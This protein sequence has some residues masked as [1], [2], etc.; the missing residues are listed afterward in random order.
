MNTQL[1]QQQQQQLQLELNQLKRIDSLLLEP[2]HQTSIFYFKTWNYTLQF[3][4]FLDLA[5]FL[6]AKKL[7]VERKRITE[8]IISNSTTKNRFMGRI[9]SLFSKLRHK[10]SGVVITQ[11]E[12]LPPPLYWIESN[13]YRF[14][15]LFCIFWV[16]E[17][18]RLAIKHA[19]TYYHAEKK[20]RMQSK[21]GAISIR[22]KFTFCLIFASIV[23]LYILL[24]PIKWIQKFT[25]VFSTMGNNADA[26]M[27]VCESR[28]CNTFSIPY[29]IIL[30]FMVPIVK[31]WKAFKGRSI[32][33]HIS[34]FLTK[35]PKIEMT[36]Y[37]IRN[38]I[39]FRRR[40]MQVIT[41]IKS[42]KRGLPIIKAI[43][44]IRKKFIKVVKLKRQQYEA[45][46]QRRIQKILWGKMTDEERRLKAVLRIQSNFRKHR[47]EKEVGKRVQLQ[48]NTSKEETIKL[49]QQTLMKRAES[50]RARDLRISQWSNLKERGDELD[51]EKKQI[52]RSIE[53]EL[54]DSLKFERRVMAI[55]K[56][57]STFWGTWHSM[58]FVCIVLE[59]LPPLLQ[60]LHLDEVHQMIRTSVLPEDN[61]FMVMMWNV[62]YLLDALVD[63]FT[64][65]FN[66]NGELVPEG[67]MARCLPLVSKTISNPITTTFAKSS[68]DLCFVH[69][70]P[71]R[72]SRWLL[73]FIIPFGN[74][75]L[76]IMIWF[77]YEF[78][79]KCN[80]GLI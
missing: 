19:R 8:T 69:A 30:Y 6:Y 64:G 74:R 71:S 36:S 32:I 11:E 56:P 23:F 60:L 7:G 43:S 45:M 67:F 63:F 59:N 66:E 25:S 51:G 12:H 57:T 33:R 20:G 49:K 44:K 75:L 50:S 10:D 5:S 77:W 13:Q 22:K 15:I 40:I 29:A 54:F 58:V 47:S 53:K 39:A 80:G 18:F 34:S 27:D 70:G 35:I 3:V 78:V 4:A 55:I 62:I 26:D 14:D 24:L 76:S 41:A 46:K 38:P 9:G 37:I 61:S 16:I 52:L 79:Q 42:V 21:D 17:G 28:D 48:R 68:L 72:M 73:A 2:R 31:A 65:R 1:S